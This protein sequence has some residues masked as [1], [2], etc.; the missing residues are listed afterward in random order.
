M[1]DIE[2][3]R[4]EDGERRWLFNFEEWKPSEELWQH[5]LSLIPAEERDRIGRFKR[6]TKEGLIV[7]R[8]NANAKSSLVGR[9][10]LRKC[11]REVLGLEELAWR[12]TAEGKPFLLN[13]P[14][15][16]QFGTRCSVKTGRVRAGYNMNLSHDGALVAFVGGADFVLGVDVMA[17]TRA[18][19]E[20]SAEFF[21]MFSDNFTAYE[22]SII[23][24]H[25]PSEPLLFESFFHHWTLKESYI[26]SIGYAF[27]LLPTVFLLCPL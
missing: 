16:E 5:C 22:W 11:A 17:N 4:V 13:T 7:G 26:K 1:D 18:G 21:D 14:D 25:A 3:R 23:K 8:H 20:P 15:T 10:L 2:R 6:P 27:P 24:S 9:L 12:R 19:S